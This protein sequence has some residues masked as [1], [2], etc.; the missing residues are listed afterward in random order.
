MLGRNA[1]TKSYIDA[2]RAKTAEQIAAFKA[3]GPQPAF[4]PQF[5]DAMVMELDQFFVHRLRMMEGKDGNPLNEVRM[6][7]NAIML[8]DGVLEIE[9]TI[10]YDAA[11]S[12]LGI[13]IGEPVRLDVARFQA[14]AEAFFDQIEAKYAA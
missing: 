7:C 4:E 6:L 9:K 8:S 12:V 11:K 5:L 3:I 14:L 13:R 1:Y 2:C 10:K